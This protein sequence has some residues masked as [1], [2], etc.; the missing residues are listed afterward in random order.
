[1]QEVFGDPQ[2]P[3][4]DPLELLIQTILSQNT[5]DRNRDRAYAAMG[6]RFPHW[7]QILTAPVEEL[8]ETIRPAGMY[9]QRAHRIQAVLRK[10]QEE[11]GELSLAFLN[12]LPLAEA[13]RWLLSLPGVGKKT[14]YIVLLFALG[15]E[16][17]PV[18]THIA[19]V[20]RRLGLWDGRGD[21]HQALA[22]LIPAGRAF[23]LH[24]NLI[25][26]GREFCRPRKPRCPQCPLLELCPYGKKEGG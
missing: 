26:L 6:A 19:R 1:M 20:T 23:P 3:H 24:L 5:S 4:L 11:Q 21:P 12:E 17:F 9:R 18:D 13:E 2:K 8:A 15:H 14:A 22:R 10:I 16:K 25:R 7:S